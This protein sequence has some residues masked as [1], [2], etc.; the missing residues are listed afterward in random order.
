VVKDGG[1]V[2][3]V[4]ACPEGVGNLE[5]RQGLALGPAEAIEKDLRREF[6]VGVHTALALRLKTT[7]LRVLALTEL[8]DDLLALAG[9]E[10]VAS[11][12]DAARVLYERHGPGAR[13]AFAPRGG[14]LLYVNRER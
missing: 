14:S 11:L 7:R 5:L 9:M 6:R 3:L 10:R 13:I 8:P 2:L 1:S 4:A 12:E